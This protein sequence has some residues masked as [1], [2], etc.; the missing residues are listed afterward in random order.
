M[1]QDFDLKHKTYYWTKER[2]HIDEVKQSRS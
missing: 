1:L 2:H